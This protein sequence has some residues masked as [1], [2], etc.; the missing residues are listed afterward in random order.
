MILITRTP[1]EEPSFLETPHMCG[2][3]LCLDFLVFPV[4]NPISGASGDVKNGK[5]ISFL[6]FPLLFAP[7]YT[8]KKYRSKLRLYD[9]LAVKELTI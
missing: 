8:W 3:R 9:W 4:A 6:F 2:L 7:G 1:K 5:E